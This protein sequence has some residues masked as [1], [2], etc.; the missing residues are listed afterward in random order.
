[1]LVAR[2]ATGMVGN[3]PLNAL[4]GWFGARDLSYLF[5]KVVC[6]NH[7]KPAAGED[8]HRTL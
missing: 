5:E 8:N 1:M 7:P 2:A 6:K 3:G 4:R